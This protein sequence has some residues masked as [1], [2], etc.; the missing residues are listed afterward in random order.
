MSPSAAATTAAAATSTA[1]ATRTGPPILSSASD[2]D[3]AQTC[4]AHGLTRAEF[5]ALREQAQG[6]KARAYCPYSH[7]RVGAA[8]LA[9]DGA[10][11][12]GANVENASYPVTTCAER[13]A[14]GRAVTD[15]HH[16][17]GFRAVAVATD[18]ASPGSPC[19]MCRQW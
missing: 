19:G 1:T 2:S 12:G 13:V 11:V 10:L 7:F 6:N 16:R 3:V 14:F 15:G 4:A 9:G 17:A 5:E 8:L 18:L